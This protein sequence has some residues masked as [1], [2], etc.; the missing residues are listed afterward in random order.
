MSGLNAGT[1]EINVPLSVMPGAGLRGQKTLNV[2]SL[3]WDQHWDLIAG[4]L[5]LQNMIFSFLSLLNSTLLLSQ[6]LI[7]KFI[8]KVI[9]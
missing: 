2:A 5:V 8:E 9:I 3:G 7:S 6:N 1:D 4:I